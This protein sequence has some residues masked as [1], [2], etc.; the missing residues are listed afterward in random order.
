MRATWA[1]DGLSTG[2]AP[3]LHCLPDITRLSATMSLRCSVS[4]SIAKTLRRTT[5]TDDTVVDARYPISGV[6]AAL[7]SNTEPRC[8][9][10]RTMGALRGP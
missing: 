5:C 10:L 2:Q 9:Q 6:I 7:A 8:T 4:S 3:L 1:T